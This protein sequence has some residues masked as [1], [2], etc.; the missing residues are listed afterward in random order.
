[1]RDAWVRAC[2]H[3]HNVSTHGCLFSFNR[4]FAQGDSIAAHFNYLIIFPLTR[5][6]LFKQIS[7]KKKTTM[8]VCF[9]I[10]M[11]GTLRLSA[12]HPFP[13]DLFF[14]FSSFF[15]WRIFEVS[16]FVYWRE[17]DDSGL[18]FIVK[19]NFDSSTCQ[20]G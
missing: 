4:M 16:V 13:F 19:F 10:M 12:F 5:I 8:C 11:S 15:S 2:N 18:S 3:R 20:L 1:M 17:L 9:L 7:K 14:F 6:Y